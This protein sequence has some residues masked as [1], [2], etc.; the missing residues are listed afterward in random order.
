MKNPD[1]FDLALD[2]GVTEIRNYTLGKAFLDAFNRTRK[3]LVNL[4]RDALGGMLIVN[5]LVWSTQEIHRVLDLIVG[6]DIYTGEN[7]R[8]RL[9]PTSEFNIRE[10]R[11]YHLVYLEQ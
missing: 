11:I 5:D 6:V 10:G 1:R 2:Q 3:G 9:E 4:S 7:S 8:L